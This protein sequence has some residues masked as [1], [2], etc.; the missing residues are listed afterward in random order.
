[1]FETLKKV[2]YDCCTSSAGDYDPARLLGYL[3]VVL[4]AMVFLVLTTYF[5][6][7]T[8]KFDSKDFALGLASISATMVAAATGV[9]IKKDTEVQPTSTAAPAAASVSKAGS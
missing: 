4:A 1:M 3:V 8:G 6:L 5:A 2:I 9:W 7:T